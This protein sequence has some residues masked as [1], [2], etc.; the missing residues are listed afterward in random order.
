MNYIKLNYHII[1]IE[2]I[3]FIHFRY[4]Y[5]KLENIEIHY[6]GGEILKL[7]SWLYKDLKEQ[8]EKIGV[9]L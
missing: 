4:S 5:G 1:F 3:S 8:I 9:E 7:D 6:I 2:N